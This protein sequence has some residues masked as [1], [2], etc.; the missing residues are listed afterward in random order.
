MIVALS[1]VIVV[2]LIRP[3]GEGLQAPAD[4]RPTGL[5]A[6][7]VAS[8][9]ATGA[10]GETDSP[11]A[12]LDPLLITCGTPSGWRAA[13]LQAWPGRTEPIR[14]WIAVQPVAASGPLDP[15]IPF[16]PV[17]TGIVTA[18]GYCAPPDD[19]RPPVI[20]RTSLWAVSAGVATPLS[21]VPLEPAT[22]NAQGGLWLAP[23][24]L[25]RS[26]PGASAAPPSADD[27]PRLWPPGR[28]ALQVAVPGGV[29]A[30][31][32]GVEV[33]DLSLLTTP[34]AGRDARRPAHPA[35]ARCEP[36]AMTR[37]RV[38]DGGARPRSRPNRGPR[39]Q[40]RGGSCETSNAP[41]AM[42]IAPAAAIHQP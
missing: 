24:E 38:L 22:P 28:Y 29:Y 5:D 40:R 10:D 11:A 2:L 6:T 35:V 21:L 20:A 13:T 3:W 7:P 23:P 18:I 12:S 34:A 15:G 30:R 39:P 42:T 4:E 19:S 26:S 37:R 17:A 1:A 14:S 36:G 16:V 8:A 25:E 32:L 27:A 9:V 33:K 31:W 41:R